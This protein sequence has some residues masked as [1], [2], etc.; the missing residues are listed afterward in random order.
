MLQAVMTIPMTGHDTSAEDRRMAAACA[1]GDAKI[2]EELYRRFGDRM[3]SIAWNHLGNAADAEDAV[4]ETFLKI[5]RAAATYSGEASFST[6]AYRILV[7][8]CY[9]VLRKRKRR[10]EETSMEDDEGM[11]I[12]RP[13]SSVDDAK[14]MT[15]R[16]L[17][18]ELP[19]QRRTVFSLFEI[20]GLSHAEIGQILGISEGNSKWILFSTK[21]ELQE[22]WN[23]TRSS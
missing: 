17:L 23:R 11:T 22:K 8:T 21:K 1:A 18:D 4:Q 20:E 19:E 9:D 10:I 13:T 3:K 2:F 6:W 7:N 5:H 15:L 16:K 14:R 12:E